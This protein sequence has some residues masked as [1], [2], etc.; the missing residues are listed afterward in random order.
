METGGGNNQSPSVSITSPTNNQSVTEGQS[1]NIT[2]NASDTDGTITKVEFFQGTTKLGEDTTKSIW[3]IPGIMPPVGSYN[4]SAVAT[5]NASA[6][7]TS[8]TV[9][10]TITSFWW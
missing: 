7:T 6:T 9:S 10:I 1:I 2:A 8:A 5:D 4:L 3:F